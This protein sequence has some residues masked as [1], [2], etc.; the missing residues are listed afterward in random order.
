[1][2]VV[3]FASGGAIPGR[4]EYLLWIKEYPRS[5]ASVPRE[6]VQSMFERDLWREEK[7]NAC[8]P[9]SSIQ[10]LDYS[11]FGTIYYYSLSSVSG[12]L[13]RWIW[14][15]MPFLSKLSLIADKIPHSS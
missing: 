6:M 11:K 13:E 4:R 15:L 3:Y 8:L 9:G 2:S 5:N 7:A 14:L 10:S 1:M 12:G